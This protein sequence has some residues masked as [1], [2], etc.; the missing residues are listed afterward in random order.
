MEVKE[1]KEIDRPVTLLKYKKGEQIIKEG[2]YGISIYKIT[3]GKVQVTVEAEGEEVLLAI[4][5]QGEILG[6]MIVLDRSVERRNATVK[7]IEDSELEAWHPQTIVNE[8]EDMPPILKYF[9]GQALS[10]LIRMNRLI[11]MLNTKE[12]QLEK[13]KKAD[14][15]VNQRRQ[16]YRKEVN[17]PFSFR[18]LTSQPQKSLSG[19]IRDISLGGVKLEVNVKDL[20][21][22]P[23][24]VGDQLIISTTLPNGKALTVVA[25]LVSI[26]KG[27][28][29]E[30]QFWGAS[31][32]ELTE[33]V[34]KILHFFLM[35]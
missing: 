29:P 9:A 31:F 23:Y 22:S 8:Y 19:I 7:A 17:L 12:Q 21:S 5:G 4:L 1:M 6:E 3:R 28:M 15:W 32:T 26:N 24:E 30:T 2:D 34:S 14:P 27:K 20:K 11:S 18:P 35:P 33:H 16:F 25:K 13:K 10:R